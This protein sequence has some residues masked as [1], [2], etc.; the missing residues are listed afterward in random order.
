MTTM[1]ETLCD[2]GRAARL[3]ELSKRARQLREGAEPAPEPPGEIT[4]AIAVRPQSAIAR[5]QLPDIDGAELL[6][7]VRAYV[8]R[9]VRF[10]SGAALD[11]SV[12]WSAHCHARDGEGTLIWPATP[13][14][15][16]LSQ[17]RG[18]G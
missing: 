11:A 3:A 1:S 18:S 16:F 15:M 17:E 8:D 4:G 7:H 12:L 14:L 13:R 5:Q 2:P 10:P 6:D 9:F